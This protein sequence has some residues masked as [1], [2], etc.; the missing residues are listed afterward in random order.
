MII[1]PEH[2]EQKIKV[3]G[4]EQTKVEPMKSPTEVKIIMMDTTVADSG[5]S[6]NPP[7]EGELPSAPA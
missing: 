5:D 3:E 7:S 2:I 4:I 6:A 1:K